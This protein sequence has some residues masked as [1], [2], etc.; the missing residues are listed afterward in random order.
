MRTFQVGLLGLGTVGCGVAHILQTNQ[1]VIQERLGA[2]IELA[3]VADLDLDR[4]RWVEVDRERMTTNA[5][6]VV[7]DPEIE[8]VVELI[9]GYE[10]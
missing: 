3:R 2:G 9:G 4:P 6:E 7:K 10:P 1:D 5:Q 8:I